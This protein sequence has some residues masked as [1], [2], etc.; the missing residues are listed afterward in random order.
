MCDM[1]MNM[2]SSFPPAMPSGHLPT[3]LKQRATYPFWDQH[4]RAL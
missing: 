2:E 4:L 1:M 3:L